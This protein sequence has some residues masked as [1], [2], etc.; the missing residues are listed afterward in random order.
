[1]TRKEI[2]LMA[3]I[4]AQLPDGTILSFPEGTSDNVI[5]NAVRQQLTVQPAPV[6]PAAAGI[7]SF[8]G[9]PGFEGRTDP[10]I[11]QIPPQQPI[12]GPPVSERLLSAA[13]RAGGDVSQV[14]TALAGLPVD[15]AT[16]AINLASEAVSGEQ[17]IDP[18]QQPGGRA[19]VERFTAGTQAGL[20]NVGR[21]VGLVD[22]QTSEQLQAERQR[23]EESGAFAAGELF[24][25]VAPFV[26]PAGVIGRIGSLVPRALATSLLGGTEAV[27]VARGRGATDED[28]QT[29]GA[30]GSG[31]GFSLEIISPVIGRVVSSIFRRVTGRAPKGQLVDANLNPTEELQTVLDDAGLSVDDVQG[32]VLQEIQ[33]G[34]IP[35][36]AERAARFRRQDIPTTRGV[37]TQDDILLGAEETLLGRTD[38][39]GRVISAPIRERRLATSAAFER[40]AQNIIDDLG[41]PDDVGNSVKDALTQRRKLLV[42]EKNA[43][44]KAAA[45]ADPELLSVPIVADNIVNA[46]PD[47]KMITRIGR[48]KPTETAAVQDL[49]IEFGIDQN[50]QRVEKFLSTADNQIEPLSFSNFED[51]RQGL[52]QI[53]RADQTGTVS[54][55]I[56]PVINVLDD[57]LD[58][59]FKAIQESPNIAGDTLDILKDARSKVRELKVEFDPQ[60]TTQKLIGFKKGNNIPI[61]ESSEVFKAITK[62]GTSVEATER[63]VKSLNKGGKVGRKALGDLQSSVVLE[64]LDKAT[65]TISS[66]SGGRQLFNANAFIRALNNIDGRG[67]LDVIFANNRGMLKT[68]RDLERS[69]RE[70]TVP[71]TTRPKG[72]APAVNAVLGVL[73]GIRALPL[74]SQISN[75]VEVGAGTVGARA[76]LDVTPQQRKTIEFVNR[77][78]PS[79]ATVLG[80][81]V[82]AERTE[83]EQ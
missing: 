63:L 1:M 60:G 64:A 62:P 78:F 43:L 76:A 81:A 7:P 44:Y 38:D 82:V 19:S 45:E 30:V 40:N 2:G 53:G 70:T 3:D 74:A 58:T 77:E 75:A 35:E 42:K 11:P 68:L 25:E 69:A 59:A 39:L 12:S 17:L 57:E 33:Q 49:L 73:N 34:A 20:R 32:Q 79:L 56:N 8:E 29:A 16:A 52:N 31:L 5:D 71:G 23:A 47:Q 65:E 41:L 14:L 4:Q 10:N 72:S 28:L 6:D 27:T 26:G 37:I 46:I 9:L 22:Q 48:L 83:N 67:K 55:L 13:N 24:G 54:N 66:R 51:F 18:E 80:V 50:P 36:Q 61:T 15:A 21:G